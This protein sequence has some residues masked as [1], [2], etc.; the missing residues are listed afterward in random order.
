VSRGVL[1]VKVWGSVHGV[2]VD[3]RGVE[4]AGAQACLA[5]LCVHLT[6]GERRLKSLETPNLTPL[7]I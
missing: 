5:V 2:T 1:V 6:V 3:A 4:S 7:L